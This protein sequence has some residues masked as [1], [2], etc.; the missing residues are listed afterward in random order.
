MMKGGSM[1]FIGMDGILGSGGI[2]MG[3]PCC[4]M[5]GF[6]GENGLEKLFGKRY[7]PIPANNTP[8]TIEGGVGVF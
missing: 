7:I 5:D 4:F 2:G 8:S 1:L 6:D 3:R